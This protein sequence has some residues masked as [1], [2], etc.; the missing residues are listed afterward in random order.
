MDITVRNSKTMLN[1][2]LIS[3]FMMEAVYCKSESIVIEMGAMTRGTKSKRDVA[4]TIKDAFI[5]SFLYN[6]IISL[7]N[8]CHRVEASLAHTAFMC[9][10][11]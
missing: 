10:S 7:R 3:V 6:G 8:P 9:F 11:P 2:K 5:F 1:G 4:K